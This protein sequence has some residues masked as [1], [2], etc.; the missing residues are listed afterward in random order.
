[1]E[2]I[3]FYVVKNKDGKYLRGSFWV[4]D[5]KRAKIHTK[6]GPALSL[7]TKMVL[8]GSENEPELVPI[9]C[10]IGEP[11]NQDERLAKVMK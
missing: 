11:I 1:M 9:I 4:T 8:N 7:I 10:T 3:E 6:R 2:T 5:L